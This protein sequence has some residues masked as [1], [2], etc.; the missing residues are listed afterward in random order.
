MFSSTGTYN[1]QCRQTVLFFNLRLLTTNLACVFQ[2]V[3]VVF[4]TAA[5]ADLRHFS[6]IQPMPFISFDTCGFF[7]S[8]VLLS[9]APMS[10]PEILDTIPA[11]HASQCN[12]Y[13]GSMATMGYQGKVIRTATFADPTD[14]TYCIISTMGSRIL[15][16]R[17]P[18]I[19][20]LSSGDQ[21][22]GQTFPG[23]AVTRH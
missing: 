16:L 22:G 23:S 13:N 1:D 7:V 21:K 8:G 10:F 3:L 11:T 15:G 18:I 5:L 4:I 2:P 19:F 6:R 12:Y 14:S 9:L 17:W 20:L